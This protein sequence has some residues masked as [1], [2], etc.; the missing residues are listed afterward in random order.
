MPIKVI[1]KL[2]VKNSKFVLQEMVKNITNLLLKFFL[3]YVVFL[4]QSLERAILLQPDDPIINMHLGDAYW[5]VKR[6]REARFQWERALVF[7]PEIKEIS[8]I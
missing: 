7:E 4:H 8:L 1:N 2:K 5:K 6:F 3:K